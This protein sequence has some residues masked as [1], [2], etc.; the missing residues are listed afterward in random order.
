MPGHQLEHLTDDDIVLDAI[1]DEV[2]ASVQI[3][4]SWLR[5]LP[6]DAAGLEFFVSDLQRWTPGQS[7][8]VAFLGGDSALHADIADA[9][10][11]IT[12]ACNIRLDFGLD[13]QTGNFRS[14]SDQDQDY[15]AEI[16]VRFDQAGYFSLVGTDSINPN[17]GSPAEAVGGRPGQ[18]SLNL[19]GFTANRPS[20]WRGVTRHEFLHALSFLHSHQNM[21]GPCEQAFRWENDEGYVPTADAQ[22]RFVTD[23][24]GRRP[25]I[26]TYLAGFPNFWSRQKVDHNLRTT[27]NPAA[28]AGPFDRQSVMLY[29]FPALFY[30]NPQTECAPLGEG[31]SLSEGDRRGLQLLYPHTAQPLGQIV[32][33]RQ[34]LLQAVEST[35]GPEL[36]G[37]EIDGGVRPSRYAQHVSTVLRKSL[38]AAK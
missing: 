32:E 8:R 27:E 14:W 35:I 22:G 30:K 28:V 26:Y 4:D 29:R 34:A 15:A 1:P 21:R 18:C 20:N 19:G 10:K 24:A 5:N 11:E 33:R 3:R 13:S 38:A 31:I 23:P 12:D 6:A 7:V 25:G 37:P 9:T 17:I 36:E 16:R 2:E